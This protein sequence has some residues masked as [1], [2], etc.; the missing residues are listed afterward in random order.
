MPRAVAG[1]QARVGDAG[2]AARSGGAG[3]GEYRPIVPNGPRGAAENRRVEIFLAPLPKTVEPVRPL[4]RRV[5][6]APSK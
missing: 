5:S 4:R 6:D 2:R 3:D 1:R